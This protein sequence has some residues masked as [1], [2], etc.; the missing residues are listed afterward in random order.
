MNHGGSPLAFASVLKDIH[1]SVFGGSVFDLI[2]KACLTLTGA[3]RGVYVT[4]AHG[5]PAE[6]RA[7]IDVNGY[8]SSSP[9]SRLLTALCRA[10]LEEEGVLA[11]HDVARWR[12]KT[13]GCSARFEK[14]IYPS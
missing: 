7:A 2:L 1:R 4:V 13:T 12:L 14:P 8:P 3:T 9:P 11:Y 10:A 6:V 5:N